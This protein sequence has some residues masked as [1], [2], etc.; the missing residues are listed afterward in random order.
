MPKKVAF[1][2]PLGKASSINECQEISVTY[3]Y[4][5][6]KPKRTGLLEFIE[7]PCEITANCF[8]E[9]VYEYLIW[10]KKLTHE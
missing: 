7:H 5:N 10:Q 6:G 9:N 4:P 2:C 8:C 3:E 1:K